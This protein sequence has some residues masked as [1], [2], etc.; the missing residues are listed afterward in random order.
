MINIVIFCNPNYSQKNII[1]TVN[2]SI[3]IVSQFIFLYK[4]IKTNWNDFEYRISLFHNKDIMFNK[5]DMEKLNK[6]DID[7]YTCKPDNP[8]L[9]YYCRCACLDTK[10][11]FKGTHRLVLDCDMIALNNPKFDL[12]CDWQ[13]MYAGSVAFNT[14]FL[15]YII[16]KYNYKFN[17]NNNFIKKDLYVKY[18]RNPNHYQKLYPYFNGGAILIKEE[19]CHTF[20]ELWK[21]SIELSYDMSLP[22][23]NRHLGL[24]Y[25][26]SYALLNLS[27]NWKP[28][29]PGINYLL[30]VY[31]VNKFG[32]QNIS[33][34]HYC[35][36]GAEK[37]V[38]KEF[39][40]YFK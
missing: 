4:S 21:P 16:K 32:K 24:Q 6:C 7:I 2:K 3:D 31:D 29:T 8:K 13:A 40:E 22:Y 37:L 30:K 20:C 11:K 33:L 23:I 17:Q 12:E 14:N 18:L 10:L 39:P 26:M 19:L 35:G 38:Q 36:V 15:D 27:R 9:P 5:I 28:F 34:L 1:N 25:S